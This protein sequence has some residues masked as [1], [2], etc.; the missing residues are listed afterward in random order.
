MSSW[1]IV[2]LD[3]GIV[4]CGLAFLTSNG[5]FHTWSFQ[6]FKKMKKISFQE[7]HEKIEQIVDEST[8]FILNNGP[9]CSVF[10]IGEINDSYPFDQMT[11][12]FTASL[13]FMLQ[14]K[15]FLLHVW[16]DRIHPTGI[17]KAM[18]S[19]GLAF[20]TACTSVAQRRSFKKK[21]TKD[22][23]FDKQTQFKGDIEKDD[24]TFD[25]CDAVFNALHFF[26]KKK[27]KLD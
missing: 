2:S 7:L 26:K 25:E 6:L 10:V 24:I 18:K 15:L 5:E 4:N 19:R 20:P 9:F 1:C 17:L 8:K 22:Y 16:V 14:Q 23:I 13:R 3:P 21:W 11:S 27:L 12:I